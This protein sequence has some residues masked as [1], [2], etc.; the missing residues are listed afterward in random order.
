MVA[1]SQS[2][3]R[4]LANKTKEPEARVPA[5]ESEARVPV[6]NP[7]AQPDPKAQAS[8]REVEAPAD[9]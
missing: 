5:K 9:L 3:A 2:K 4:A 7:K 6:E 8:S 1:T